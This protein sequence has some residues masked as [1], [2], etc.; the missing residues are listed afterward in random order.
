MDQDTIGASATPAPETETTTAPAPL[1]P[2]TQQEQSIMDLA[3][4]AH[5]WV[6]LSARIALGQVR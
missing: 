2:P 4:I 6:D 1:P 5:A 3:H